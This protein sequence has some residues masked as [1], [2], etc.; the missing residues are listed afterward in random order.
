MIYYLLGGETYSNWV[1]LAGMV[2]T[3]VTTFCA[4]LIGKD[5]LP[6][7]QGRAFAVN[8]QKSKGKP[9]G[10][11]IYF[12]I[13]FVLNAVL[14]VPFKIE[15]AIYLLLVTVAMLTGF[16]DDASE[17]PWGE[18]KK[19][20]LDFVITVGLAVTYLYF[21]DNEIFIP[22]MQEKVAIPV[23]VYGILIVIL[24]WASINV[25]N[26]AD[27]VD[28]LCACL[29]SV[30]LLSV[31]Y[32]SKEFATDKTFGQMSLFLVAALVAYLWFN[33][34]PSQL[35]MGDAGSRAIGLFIAIAMIKSCNP[36]LYIPIA[37]IL[38]LD[39]GLGLIKLTI[40]RV[41]KTKKFMA[42]LRTP[43]HDH[44]RKNKGWSDTQVVI[45]FVLIQLAISAAV[46]IS[47]VKF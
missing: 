21:N 2:F 36:I 8:G 40:M 35:L 37:L 5:K 47:V 33:A 28:G 45:R 26:C 32:I 17:K 20:I 10:A 1:M 39:G 14:F 41:F 43:I 27:G 6:T 44:M 18:L 25:T 24:A 46:V 30:T 11:G 29:S 4:I 23:V 9:R 13:F 15:Y 12:V 31:Y 34:S 3:L 42:N 7:D 38:I 19:G 22:F 16:F